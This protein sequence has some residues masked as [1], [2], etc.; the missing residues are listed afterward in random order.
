VSVAPRDAPHR[1]GVEDRP[2]PVQVVAPVLANRPAGAYRHLVLHAPAAAVGARAGQF[3]ALSVGDRPTATLLRRA[4]SLL[5]ADPGRGTLEL[6]VAAHGPGT[7]WLTRRREGDAVDVVGPLGRPF[8]SPG[9]DRPRAVLVGGGYGAAPLLWLAADLRAAGTAVDV[10]LGAGDERRLFGVEAARASADSVHVTT[11]DGSAGTRG[12][13]TDVLPGVLE[14]A[15]EGPGGCTVYACGPMGMLRA[16][17]G[18][19]AAA[20][21]LA[22]CTVE[23][24]MA[25]GI[26]VCMTCVLPVRAADGTTR[27]TRSCVEG[28]TLAGDAV[29]WD[30]VRA[31][32]PGPGRGAAVAGSDVPADCWGA[33][34]PGGH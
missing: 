6:V 2:R 28:P 20:G 23:E 1:A 27:M 13:V 10:V 31:A 22:W 32:V 15:G 30:A 3:L 34:R 33:P 21:A 26:G 9:A 24:A 5:A 17:A 25:C 29:R 4:V 11:D 8:P 19:A 7:A 18:V 14:R 16:V 12:R